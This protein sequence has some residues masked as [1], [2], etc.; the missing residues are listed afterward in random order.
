MNY[1]AV[2]E[3][4]KTSIRQMVRVTLRDVEH[5]NANN[6]SL[7][8]LGMLAYNGKKNSRVIDDLHTALLQKQLDNG[9]WMNELWGT[10]L[11]LMAIHQCAKQQGKTFNYRAPHIRKALEYIRTTRCDERWNWQGEFNETILL[12]WVFLRIENHKEYDFVEGAI[13]RLKSI[14]TDEGYLFDIYDT[15]MAL[16]AFHAAEKTLHMEKGDESQKAI[17]WLKKWEPDT[18]SAWNRAVILFMISEMDTCDA[19]WAEA[20]I[21]SFLEELHH[22]IISDDHDEQ[23]MVVL[24]LSSFLNQ[25]FADDFQ[26]RR[27]PIDNLFHLSIYDDYLQS[28]RDILKTLIEAI[29]SRS[30]PE[31]IFTYTDAFVANYGTL[32]VRIESQDQ[33]KGMITAFYM[34]FYEASGSA[35][36]IPTPFLNEDSAIFKI[37][38]LRTSVQHDFQHGAAAQIEKK[39]KVIEDIYKQCCGKSRPYDKDDFRLVH[40]FLLDE[41]E[42]FLKGIDKHLQLWE[43]KEAT[44]AAGAKSVSA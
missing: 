15:A 25:C 32:F 20:I 43:R 40:L 34:A 2:T 26:A 33:F 42:H 38:H 44:P 1:V 16:C 22:G 41:T 30:A 6:L 31:R 18:E 10:G 39:T 8:I 9:S 7:S 12:C 17:Q 27:V 24:A 21:Q 5:L 29:N 19:E 36:R 37:K 11:A 14:Q 4:L 3:A 28:S 35:K 13:K 23:A